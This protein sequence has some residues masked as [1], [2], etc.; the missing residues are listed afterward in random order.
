MSSGGATWLQVDRTKSRTDHRPA[1]TSTEP[2]WGL[3]TIDV[4]VA[5]GNLVDLVR[6]ESASYVH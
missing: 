5:L 2:R 6:S 3:H 4:N 1:Y